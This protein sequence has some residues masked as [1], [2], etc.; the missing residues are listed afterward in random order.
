MLSDY[1]R[2]YIAAREIGNKQEMQQI[3]EDLE[4]LGMDRQT[5]LFFVGPY[6]EETRK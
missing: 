4:Q 1:L 5:L 6:Y 2:S 3:E